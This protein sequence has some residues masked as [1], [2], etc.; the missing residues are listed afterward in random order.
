M[1]GI[2]AAG[3]AVRADAAPEPGPCRTLALQV[4]GAAQPLVLELDRGRDFYIVAARPVGA[5]LIEQLAATGTAAVVAPGGG[6]IGNLEVWEN[7]ALP[8]AWRG[9]P[10]RAALE[11]SARAVLGELGFAGPRFSALCSAMPESLSPFEA[12]A[13]AFARAMLLEPEIMVFDRLFEALGGDERARAARLL[14]LFQRRFPFRTAVLI[15]A[16]TDALPAVRSG[17]AYDL[18]GQ[19]RELP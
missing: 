7:L 11:A 10:P 6:L 2:S 13:V 17:R 8:L 16:E 9:A 4:P 18:R 5:L 14:P 15:E 12:K 3:M 1:A 19:P